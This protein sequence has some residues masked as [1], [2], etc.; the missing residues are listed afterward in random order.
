[1]KKDNKTILVQNRKA[2]FNYEIIDTYM[3][4]IVL[5]GDEVKSLKAHNGTISESYCYINEGECFIT[6]MYIKGNPCAIRKDKDEMRLRKLLLNKKEIVYL[7]EKI[8]K[9]GM[10]LIPLKVINHKGFVKLIIG[11]C[12]GKKLYDKRNSIKERDI[13]KEIDRNL[14]I[15]I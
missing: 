7:K 8:D 9:N 10:T 3:T 4:G 13:Q 6:N 14:K 5:Y 1:M 2:N 11:L 12:K 15:I